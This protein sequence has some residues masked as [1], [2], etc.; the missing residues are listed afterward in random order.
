MA[1]FYLIDRS[2]N[3]A[4]FR[5]VLSFPFNSEK[6]IAVGITDMYL[7]DEYFGEHLNYVEA[8]IESQTY[9]DD[10]VVELTVTMLRSN[11]KYSLYAYAR[12]TDG[13]WYIVK[14]EYGIIKPSVTTHYYPPQLDVVTD[15]EYAVIMVRT[16][17]YLD[18]P[19]YF[20]PFYTTDGGNI[21]YAG[22][23]YIGYIKEGSGYVYYYAFTSIDYGGVT[24]H[25][26]AYEEKYVYTEING[27]FSNE[28]TVRLKPPGNL[29]NAISGVRITQNSNAASVVVYDNYTGLY[30]YYIASLYD[31][32]NDEY[33]EEYLIDSPGEYTFEN[34]PIGKYRVE[35]HV[36]YNGEEPANFQDM[37]NFDFTLV[38]DYR[39]LTFTVSAIRPELWCWSDSERAAFENSGVTTAL[40]YGRW[41]DFIDNIKAV[42]YFKGVADE[43][44]EEEFY[45]VPVGTTVYDFCEC[46][47]AEY[48]GEEIKAN[49]FNIARHT[50][51]GMNS[52]GIE[53]KFPGN[54]VCGYEFITLEEKLNDIT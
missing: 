38:P 28:I 8:I 44:L 41:N 54:H 24:T 14:N 48:S 2:Y 29:V 40:T 42:A 4:T 49:Q 36:Y 31:I 30:D 37:Y 45:N 43:Q 15:S 51:G 16:Y 27:N 22:S 23:E 11:T 9:T 1:D 34:I 46:A 21:N 13:T 53:E 5:I 12:A 32:N 18:E 6:Y 19:E 33:I 50:I 7:G 39:A 47:K 35:V 17:D 3:E 26:S 10:Y 25:F 20:Y 52:T